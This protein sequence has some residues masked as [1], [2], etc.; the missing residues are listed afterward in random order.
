MVHA[1]LSKYKQ[2]AHN[3]QGKVI[4]VSLSACSRDCWAQRSISTNAIMWI[5]GI[6]YAQS[7][8]NQYANRV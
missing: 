4:G 5:P 8:F 6:L 3:T 2:F 7:A 1:D